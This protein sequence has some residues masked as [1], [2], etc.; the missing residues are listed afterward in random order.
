M[1]LLSLLSSSRRHCHAHIKNGWME[2]GRRR[3]VEKLQLDSWQSGAWKDTTEASQS[4]DLH[5]NTESDTAVNVI[6]SEFHRKK[7]TSSS[8]TNQACVWGFTVFHCCNIWVPSEVGGWTIWWF[9]IM[10]DLKDVHNLLFRWIVEIVCSIFCFQTSPK[11]TVVQTNQHSLRNY[12]QLRFRCD[13]QPVKRLFVWKRQ[14]WLL[15]RLV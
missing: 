12:C 13:A 3:V 4:F 8:A 14:W 5:L 6:A 9:Y 7:G 15:K 10:I 11:P 2:E 1:R